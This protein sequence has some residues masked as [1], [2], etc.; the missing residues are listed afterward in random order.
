[1]DVANWNGHIKATT[2]NNKVNHF[3]FVARSIFLVSNV[4]ILQV[5]GSTRKAVTIIIDP[6]LTHS[7]CGG[8]DKVFTARKTPIL[9]A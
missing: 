5:R 4:D 9:Q 8:L 1:M 6:L 7:L 2:V 3:F